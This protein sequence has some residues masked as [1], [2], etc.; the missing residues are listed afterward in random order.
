MQMIEETGVDGVTIA[1]GCIG[2]PWIF[3]ECR[4]LYRGEALPPPPAI[5]EQ[6]DAIGSHW[7]DM[8]EVYGERLAAKHIRKFGIKY[9]EHHPLARE[10]RDAFV[11]VKQ[12]GDIDRVLERWYDPH[13]DWPPVRR[14]E[15]HGDLIAA[16]ATMPSGEADTAL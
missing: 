6:R 12:P 2:N 13:G 3:Q 11:A 9:S 10:V 16:G 7:V 15:S 4:A 1:R 8:V 5:K 14:R